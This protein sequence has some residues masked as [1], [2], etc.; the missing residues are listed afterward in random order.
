MNCA[1]W[2]K[3]LMIGFTIPL[4]GVG[5][6]KKMFADFGTRRQMDDVFLSTGS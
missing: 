6:I 2:D 3:R 1:L 4:N 5:S